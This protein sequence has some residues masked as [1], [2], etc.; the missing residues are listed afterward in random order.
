MLEYATITVGVASPHP[1][2]SELVNSN[3]RFLQPPRKFG[4]NEF[5]KI[6]MDAN[7]LS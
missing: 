4:L 3:V 5:K 7:H 2:P 6:K 1:D